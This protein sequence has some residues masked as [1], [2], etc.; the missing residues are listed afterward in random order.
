LATANT[1]AA[2]AAGARQVEVTVNGLGERAGNAPLEEVVMALKT[3]GQAFGGPRVGI[4][5]CQIVPASRLASR[6]TGLQ[7][8]VN[9]AV[10][11]A[12]AF[13]HE[14]GIHQDGVIKERTTYEIMRP[15]DVGWESSRLVL[16]KHSGRHGVAFRLAQLGIELDGEALDR[17]YA[18][19]I[20]LADGKKEISDAMLRELAEA[21]L[22]PVYAGGRS[23]GRAS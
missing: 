12:N 3:R 9:K 7:V 8:Q 14:A 10:V 23:M 11:G 15:A 2:V 6:I 1:L 17:V 19:F 4:N 22:Q 5:T 13:A 20:E 21:Q 18:S 16:G